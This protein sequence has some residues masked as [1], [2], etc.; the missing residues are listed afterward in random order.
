[1]R[2]LWKIKK[3]ELNHGA[4]VGCKCCTKASQLTQFSTFFIQ[5]PTEEV[6]YLLL[7]YIVSVGKMFSKFL[8]PLLCLGSALADAD[9]PHFGPQFAPAPYGPPPPPAYGPPAYG[10]PPPPPP[11]PVYAPAPVPAYA[12]VPAFIEPAR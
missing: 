5:T 9:G 2:V 8:V 11:P 12:P 3:A 10:P 1:L 7:L 4:Q 6:T